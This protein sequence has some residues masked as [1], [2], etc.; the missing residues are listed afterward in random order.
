V[1]ILSLLVF[2]AWSGDADAALN[3]L[4]PQLAGSAQLGD[5]QEVVGA[6]ADAEENLPAVV[7]TC[8]PAA[9]LCG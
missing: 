4:R 5:R 2:A 6:Q 8:G 3:D 1:L 9:R 7:W